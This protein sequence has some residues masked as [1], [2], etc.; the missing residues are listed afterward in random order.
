MQTFN[1]KSKGFFDVLRQANAYVI[2]SSPKGFVFPRFHVSILRCI[3][4]FLSSL[5]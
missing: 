1:L 3:D 4:E 2:I 5:V